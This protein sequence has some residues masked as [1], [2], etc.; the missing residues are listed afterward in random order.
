ARTLQPTAIHAELAL[1]LVVDVVIVAADDGLRLG[2]L[3]LRCGHDP[4]VVL[5]VLEVVLGGHAVARGL[6]V[7]R[8]LDVFLGDVPRGT[9]QLHITAVALVG[10]RERVGTFAV[11]PAHT[12]VLLSLP[13]RELPSSTW[14][15]GDVGCPAAG[16]AI[17]RPK[18]WPRRGRPSVALSI[19]THVG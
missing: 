3:S 7:P 5:R 11:T 19:G 8:E 18:Q 2:H 4:V 10:A 16:F 1:H 14:E 6:R 15:K 12:L 9:P 13:H 17:A